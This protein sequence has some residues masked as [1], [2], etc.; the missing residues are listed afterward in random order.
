M[1][2]NKAFRFKKKHGKAPYGSPRPYTRTLYIRCDA[3]NCGYKRPISRDLWHSDI[4]IECPECGHTDY[5]S[6]I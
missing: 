2:P 5:W 6:P 4:T 1:N 3:T